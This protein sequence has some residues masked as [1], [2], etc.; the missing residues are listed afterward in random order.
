MFS[1]FDF[2]IFCEWGGK[3]FRKHHILYDANGGWMSKI[4]KETKKV[5]IGGRT[6]NEKW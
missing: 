1:C 2:F 4:K 3:S 6:K 5:Y